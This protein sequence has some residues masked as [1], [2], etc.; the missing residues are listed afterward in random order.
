MKHSLAASL[1][2][3]LL[4]IVGC[5]TAPKTLKNEQIDQIKKVGIVTSLKY[6]ELKVFDH[7]GISNLHFTNPGQYAQYG[8]VGGAIGGLLE[9]LLI[10]IDSGAKIKNSLGGDPD[11]LRHEI[12]R[13][14]VI[15]IFNSSLK[16]AISQSY[17]TEYI[18]YEK[19]GFENE[20]TI[21]LDPINL[22]KSI[23]DYCEKEKIDTLVFIDFSYGVAAYHGEKSS[24][25]INAELFFTDVNSKKLILNKII[26]SDALFYSGRNIDEFS[27]N[28]AELYKQDIVKASEACSQLIGAEM[29]INKNMINS[30]L[31]CRPTTYPWSQTSCKNPFT[32]VQ[33]CSGF[34]GPKL[35]VKIND[36][37]IKIAGSSDG[38]IILFRNDVPLISFGKTDENE[39]AF[40]VVEAA[41]KSQN[42]KILEK[43]K[44]IEFTQVAGYIIKLDGDGYSI[45]KSYCLN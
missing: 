34:S 36:Q 31:P 21:P 17:S 27:N 39:M 41:L 45:L 6:K 44:L 3:T 5:A 11:I 26:T 35:V 24:A 30:S 4:L 19:I 43:I 13:L 23:L 12:G 9:G 42:I 15:G 1:L 33:D 29:D 28:H 37:Q 16:K 10:G 8:A 25:V 32:F 20:I 2:L 38:K 14:D 7:S 18:N 22:P 40:N